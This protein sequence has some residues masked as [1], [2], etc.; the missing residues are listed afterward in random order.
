MCRM[1]ENVQK[2]EGGEGE[3]GDGSKSNES[4]YSGTGQYSQQI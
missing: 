1:G 2:R 4:S 3:V